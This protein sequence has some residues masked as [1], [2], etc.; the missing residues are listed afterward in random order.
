[1]MRTIRDA[2]HHGAEWLLATGIESPRLEAR[3]LLAHA[4]GMDAAALLRNQHSVVD[5]ACYDALLARRVARE[6]VA[7]IVGHR[8]FWSLDFAV[9]PAT[10]IPRPES[11]TVVEAALAAFGTGPQ[12]DPPDAPS[13]MGRGRNLLPSKSD[14]AP[15]RRILDLGTGTGCLLLAVLSEFPTA[16]G[17]GVDRCPAAA[18]L[19]ARNAAV[20]GMADRAA[21]LCGDWSAALAG[22]FEI[23]LCNPPYIATTDLGDLMPDVARYEP[24]LA[25]DGGSDGYVAYRYLIPDLARLLAPDGIAAL[26]LGQGQA[27]TVSGLALQAGLT[28]RAHRDLSGIERALVLR[29]PNF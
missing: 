10:L 3:L 28:A 29:R 25:L 24:A 4:L 5:M 16:F 6:P 2:L 14:T 7:L 12:R 21:F 9:S 20:L 17:V 26:E 8:E 22:R 27:E 1:M 18:A 13:R 11:E 19:A 15:P 23:I